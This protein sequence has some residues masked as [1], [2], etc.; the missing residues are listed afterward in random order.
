MKQSKC[1]LGGAIFALMFNQN[2]CYSDENHKFY[3]EKTIHPE[4]YLDIDNTQRA[5]EKINMYGRIWGQ[6]FLDNPSLKTQNFLAYVALIPTKAPIDNTPDSKRGHGVQLTARGSRVGMYAKETV[7]NQKL[8]ARIEFDFLTNTPNA[9]LYNHSYMP[10]VRHAY[11]NTKHLLVGQTVSVF[12][13]NFILSDSNDLFYIVGINA[14]RTPQIRYTHEIGDSNIFQI[15]MENPESDYVT[16][17]KV[18]DPA[19]LEGLRIDKLPDITAAFLHQNDHWGVGIHGLFRKISIDDGDKVKADVYGY[20]GSVSG[21]I[22][23]TPND[24]LYGQFQGGPGLGRY[25][26]DTVGTAAAYNEDTGEFVAQ[27]TIG[28][29]VDLKHIFNKHFRVHF[30]GGYSKLTPADFILKSNEIET[31]TIQK[32]FQIT[33]VYEPQSGYN[34]KLSYQYA[35]REI[36]TGEKGHMNRI[37]LSFL[38]NF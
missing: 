11:L 5:N 4:L 3:T 27:N 1:L 23:L 24:V 25:M 8:Y 15:A 18:V 13:N 33:G 6:L 16:N 22:H 21:Y 32:C 37:E 36:G 29:Y 12:S 30:T 19:K 35:G 14:K 28:G 17:K 9:E 38:Y 10:R 2:T 7:N 26:L 20:A 31:T 34:I